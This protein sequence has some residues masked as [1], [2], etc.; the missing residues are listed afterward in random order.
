MRPVMKTPLD[1]CKKCRAHN[2]FEVNSKGIASLFAA[3]EPVNVSLVTIY[4]FL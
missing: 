3:I 2:Q 4:E 1:W